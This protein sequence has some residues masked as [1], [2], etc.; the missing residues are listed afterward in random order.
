MWRTTPLRGLWAHPPYFHDGSATT[1]A[2]VVSRYDDKQ[3]TAL[4]YAE[5]IVWDLPTDD[6]LWDRL[7]K[8]FT[9]P[10]IVEL[11]FFMA[12]TMGQGRWL[13]TLNIEHHQVLAGTSGA[14]APGFENSD[15]LQKSKADPSYWANLQTRPKVEAAE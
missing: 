13:R 14:M 8:H 11:G 15:A 7:Y 9:I 10:Q 4:A 3:K 5:A 2:D 1:L 6:A 12:I